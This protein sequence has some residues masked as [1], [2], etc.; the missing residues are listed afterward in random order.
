MRRQTSFD[1]THVIMH[2]TGCRA[3]LRWLNINTAALPNTIQTAP[4]SDVI[5]RRDTSRLHCRDTQHQYQP[6]PNTT[7]AKST[8]VRT[9]IPPMLFW[10]KYNTVSPAKLRTGSSVPVIAQQRTNTQSKHNPSQ[11]TLTTARSHRT[12]MLSK[13]DNKH[14]EHD[15]QSNTCR[16]ARN[17]QPRCATLIQH[18]HHNLP[19]RH[20]NSTTMRCDSPMRFLAS[21]MQ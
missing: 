18:Q 19:L 1:Q 6:H 4:Q 13:H 8:T 15:T 12:A 9:N 10:L 17:N 20:P 2:T 3:A 21:T 11:Q 16:H 5:L 7:A 14:A